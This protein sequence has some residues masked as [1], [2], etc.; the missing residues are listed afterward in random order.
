MIPDLTYISAPMVNQSDAPF[1]LLTRRYGATLTYTQMLDPHKLLNDHDYL[2]FHLRD[3]QSTHPGWDPC[4]RPVV[5]QLCGNDPETVVKAARQVQTYCDGIDLN[6]GCPQEHARDGHFGGYL[7]NKK[8][9]PLVECIVS[10]MSHSLTVPSSAKIR[11]CP[12]AKTTDFGH[13][14]EHAGAS[15][16][17]LHARHVSAKRRRQGAADLDAVRELKEAL[18]VPVVSNGN[19]RAFS[20]IRNNVAYTRADGAMVGETLLG[21]PCLFSGSDIQDPV[22]ISLEYLDIC[23]LLPHVAT[24]KT[25]QAHVR[26]IIEFQC[27]RRPWY[28]KFRLALSNCESLDDIEA[29]LLGK[30]TRWR[31]KAGKLVDGELESSRHEEDGKF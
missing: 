17:T 24:L 25:I 22:L 1:R 9:W 31:G 13:L 20:D 19:V 6:L 30:V 12:S 10:A 14:L 3:L 5:V 27:V 28:S 7:L 15:W 18:A 23:K 21:N 29:L 2:E 8:D 26:Y 16:V 4:A 11:L